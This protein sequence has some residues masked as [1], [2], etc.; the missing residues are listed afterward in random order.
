M[1]AGVKGRELRIAST[2]HVMVMNSS[3]V[4]KYSSMTFII[5][6]FAERTVAS[7]SPPKCGVIGGL[8][9]HVQVNDAVSFYRLSSISL[10]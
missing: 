3:N 7:Q 10:R 8:K 6:D 4:N 9:C 1:D 2:Q 5:N